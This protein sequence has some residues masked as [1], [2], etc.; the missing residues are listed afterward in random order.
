MGK[1]LSLKNSVA[2]LNKGQKTI[3]ARRYYL[4]ETQTEIASELGLSQ[5][6][7][8]RLEKSALNVI[9]KNYPL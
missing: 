7:I 5:A 4:G 1:Y 8:S 3:I 2:R 9:Q 6:Q